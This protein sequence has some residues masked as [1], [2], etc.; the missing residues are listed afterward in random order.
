MDKPLHD[1]ADEARGADALMTLAAL[2]ASSEERAPSE[3]IS[4]GTHHP[5]QVHTYKFGVL[6]LVFKLFMAFIGAILS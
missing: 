3:P 5:S 2:A 4:E 6:S 1:G